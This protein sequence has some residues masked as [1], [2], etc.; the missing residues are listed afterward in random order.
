MKVLVV[1]AHPDDETLSMGGT[2]ANHILKGDD[3]S[4]LV[5][6]NNYRDPNIHLSFA[7]AMEILGVTKYKLLNLPDS[8]LENMLT[9]KLSSLIED[10]AKGNYPDL[11]YTHDRNELSQDHL[12]TCHATLIAFRPVSKPVSI[13]SFESPSSSEWSGVPFNANYF[14]DIKETLRIKLQ[15]LSCYNTEL[16]PFPHPRS[17]RSLIARS[18]YW[19]SFMGLENA[20]AFSVVR[21]I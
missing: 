8:E 11:V 10:Y 18:N 7:N 14:T 19:G 20:E 15:A 4:V 13:L 2:I 21:L 3:V 5:M 16:R 1:C 6:T 12:I 9:M 17:Q